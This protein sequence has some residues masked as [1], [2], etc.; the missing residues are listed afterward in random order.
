MWGYT[1]APTYLVSK[2]EQDK[3]IV[4][5]GGTNGAGKKPPCLNQYL[6]VYTARNFGDKKITKKTIP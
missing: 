6:C 5:Y 4:L 3:P 2:V 1:R